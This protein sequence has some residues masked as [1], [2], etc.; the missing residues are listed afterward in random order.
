M[1]ERNA[2]LLAAALLGAAM[3]H[4][5]LYTMRNTGGFTVRMNRLTGSITVCT[6]GECRSAS[7]K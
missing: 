2:L 4:G 5:G 7:E 1:S 6:G 3:L